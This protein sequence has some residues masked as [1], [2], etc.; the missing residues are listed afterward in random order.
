MYDLLSGLATFRIRDEK[1]GKEKYKV[2]IAT[3]HYYI[4]YSMI[5]Y[6]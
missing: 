1:V 5:P 2:F 3:A 4:T 6:Y